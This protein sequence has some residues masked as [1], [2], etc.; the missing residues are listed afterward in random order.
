MN[1]TKNTRSTIVTA[2]AAVVLAGAV[3][4]GTGSAANASEPGVSGS[5]LATGDVARYSL[6]AKQTKDIQA[7]AKLA[8]SQHAKM[9]RN[10][11]SGGNYRISTGNGYYGAY[12]FDRGTWTSNGG[13]QFGKTA[14]KAP[15]WAQDYVMY[16]THEARGWSPWGG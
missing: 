7:A 11:E 9:I 1:G 6:S 12:Q 14:D 8:S 10:R 15:K 2:A 16:K 13:G 5:V 3:V 4:A